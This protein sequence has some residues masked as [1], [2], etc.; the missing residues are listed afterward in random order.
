M[1]LNV[2]CLEKNTFNSFVINIWNRKE[3]GKKIP[4]IPR[5]E[6][7]RMLLWKRSSSFSTHSGKC[8]CK[9]SVHKYPG[10]LYMKEQRTMTPAGK[11]TLQRSTCHI[12]PT[13]SYRA[14][15]VLSYPNY[16]AWLCWSV[17]WILKWTLA[18]GI[19]FFSYG[20]SKIIRKTEEAW[21][22]D[23]GQ[24]HW[25]RWSL[26][27]HRNQLVIKVRLFFSFGWGFFG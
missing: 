15:W 4:Q 5:G 18:A 7:K 23:A 8:F 6:I 9:A 27:I 14:G 13:A 22:F 3:G 25:F 17:R 1:E 20:W 21:R 2:F 10:G 12:C 24:V 16:T 11:V 19:F 26:K